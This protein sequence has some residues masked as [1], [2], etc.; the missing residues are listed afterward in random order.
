M[1]RAFLIQSFGYW[2]RG[3]T[4]A[5]AAEACR[6]AGASKTDNC[7]IDLFLHPTT[8][9]LPAVI[10]GGMSVEYTMGSE[11]IRICKCIKLGTALKFEE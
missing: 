1:K 5:K 10:Q 3:E 2:G 7:Y 11:K 4:V 8:N 9:P 6:K